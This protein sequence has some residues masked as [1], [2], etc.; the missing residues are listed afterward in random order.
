MNHTPTID[1]DGVVSRISPP[2]EWLKQL[3]FNAAQLLAFVDATPTTEE[4]GGW[5]FLNP[6]DLLAWR[7][8]KKRKKAIQELINRGIV[9]EMRAK[10]RHG[11]IHRWLRIVE[12]YQL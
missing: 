8:K 9:E 4:N 1:P 10:N 12:G 7:A 6:E 5:V 11:D 2:K 3:S